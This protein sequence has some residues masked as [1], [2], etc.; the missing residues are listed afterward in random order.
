MLF[1][2]REKAMVCVRGWTLPEA[3]LLVS[4]SVK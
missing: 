3:H 4:M 1:G 2:Q